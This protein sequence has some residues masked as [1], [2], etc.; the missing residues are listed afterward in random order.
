MTDQALP[1]PASTAS[2]GKLG[3][4]REPEE[5]RFSY[6]PRPGLMKLTFMNLLL[7]II[8]LSFYRFWAKTNVRQHIWSCVHINGEPLEYTG[9][10]KELF[11]GF[12]M[13]FGIFFLPYI[14]IT[15][16]LTVYL[17]PQSPVLS[18][19]QGLFFLFIYVFWGFAV[20]R[21]RKYQLSRTNWRGIRGSLVGSAMTYSLLYFGSLLAKGMSMGWATPVMN[22]VLQEQ[23]TN[24]MRFGDAAFKFKGRAGALYPTYAL[25]WFL[26][27]GAF[28]VAMVVAAGSAAGMSN[29]KDLFSNADNPEN[30]KT[31]G[32]MIAIF[33]GFYL[34]L[35]LLIIPML[36]AIYIAKEMR[37]FANYTRF[38]GAPFTMN[39][40][41]WSVIRLTVVN[42]LLLVFTLGIAWP[43]INQR[44][45]RFITERITLEGKVDIDRIRQSQ[46]AMLKRGEGLAAAFD[47]GGL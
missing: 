30:A 13:I 26:T 19:L 28:I 3:L 47:V 42:L 46:E 45:V 10:G 16:F 32:I 27:L 31:I 36:W 25:C 43:F 20:Y 44:L 21:A 24:D 4:P 7:N 35:A 37:I 18:L 22:T 9:T 29:F 6:V 41:A 1:Q 11:L 2:F 38:D 15:A 39:A 5:L 14:A 17:G 12:L 33:I 40:T 23:I 34:L 8:T